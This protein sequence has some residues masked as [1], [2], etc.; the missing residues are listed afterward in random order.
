[1][2]GHVARVLQVRCEHG[3]IEMHLPL[4]HLADAQSGEVPSVQLTAQI[5]VRGHSLLVVQV[6][7]SGVVVVSEEILHGKVTLH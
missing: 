7:G 4:T 1:L 5:L 3:A 2:Y 6:L